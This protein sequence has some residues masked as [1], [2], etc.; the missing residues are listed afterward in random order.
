M[1]AQSTYIEKQ[2]ESDYQINEQTAVDIFFTVVV[3]RNM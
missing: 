2:S 1:T 3:L